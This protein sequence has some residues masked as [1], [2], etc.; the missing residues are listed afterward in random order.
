[1]ALAGSGWTLSVR[2]KLLHLTQ[3]LQ[4][5]TSQVSCQNVA[6]PFGKEKLNKIFNC[7]ERSKT[8]L[9]KAIT[10]IGPPLIVFCSQINV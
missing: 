8:Q 1:M 9:N 7:L 4:H 2:R 3:H 6:H 5:L 10:E